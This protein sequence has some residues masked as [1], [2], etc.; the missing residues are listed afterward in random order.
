[1][2]AYFGGVGGPTAAGR[3]PLRLRFWAST[4]ALVLAADAGSFAASIGL[5]QD[6]LVEV[7]HNSTSWR[8]GRPT[9]FWASAEGLAEFILGSFAFTTLV[10][11]QVDIGH[12]FYCVLHR[13]AANRRTLR[14]SR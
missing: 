4:A 10:P 3:G 5:A 2:T 13:A 7:K 8:P 9:L 6:A 14:Y 11:Y 1:L 12:D